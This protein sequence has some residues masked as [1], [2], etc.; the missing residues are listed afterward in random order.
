MTIWLITHRYPPDLAGGVERQMHAMAQA[1]RAEGHTVLVFATRAFGVSLPDQVY[2]DI[3]VRRFDWPP[4]TDSNGWKACR[5]FAEILEEIA[6][7]PDVVWTPVPSAAV[8]AGRRFRGRVNVV[9]TP[10]QA[11]PLRASWRFRQFLKDVRRVGLRW[12]ATLWTRRRI[13]LEAVKSASTSVLASKMERAW[14]LEGVNNGLD[15]V[16]LPR[17]VE[18]D[19]WTA[20]ASVSR[21]VQPGELRI[22]VASR[23]DRGKNI[24]QVIRAVAS[25]ADPAVRLTIHGRGPERQRLQ[26]LI[27]DLGCADVVHLADWADDMALAYSRHD[28]FVLSSDFDAFG[29]TPFEALASGCVVLVRRPDPPRVI[30]GC[31]EWLADCPACIIYDT[32]G[33]EDLARKIRTLSADPARVRAL[34]AQ[35]LDWPG[36][37]PWTAVIDQYIHT[38]ASRN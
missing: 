38:E 31:A 10:G 20:G 32:Y 29:L 7:A 23:L 21:P 27:D 9:F 19:R 16:V 2:E 17:G 18:L 34:S 37:R 4:H 12:A 15:M 22:L 14:C 25:V 36:L 1:A 5:R 24:E 30:I 26:R 3:P 28:V 8:A 13:L 33:H 35:A 11:V 6:G